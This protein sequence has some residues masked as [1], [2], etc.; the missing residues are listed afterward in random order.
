MR[1][2]GRGRRRQNGNGL[3]YYY[4]L[5][6]N[7]RVCNIIYYIIMNIVWFTTGEDLTPGA[8]PNGFRCPAD[9]V[10]TVIRESV[11]RSGGD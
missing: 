9:R 2:P 5:V 1:F 7:T 3:Y 11:A 10:S 6:S 8:A 4:D